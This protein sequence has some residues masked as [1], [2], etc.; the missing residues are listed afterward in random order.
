MGESGAVREAFSSAVLCGRVLRKDRSEG[1]GEV[2]RGEGEGAGCGAG[3]PS[4]KEGMVSP[5][6]SRHGMENLAAPG[7]QPRMLCQPPFGP[8]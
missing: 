3:S 8:V 5:G 2:Q 4:D 6:H 7:C 1:T